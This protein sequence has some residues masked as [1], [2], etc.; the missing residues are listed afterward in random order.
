V[1]GTDGTAVL[2]Y[3]TFAKNATNAG[4]S[5]RRKIAVALLRSGDFAAGHCWRRGPQASCRPV[6]GWARTWP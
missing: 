1:A 4:R 2:V 3:L 6:R 5:R